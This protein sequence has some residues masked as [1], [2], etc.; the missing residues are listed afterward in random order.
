MSDLFLHGR[1]VDTVFDL[2][3]GQE[4]DITCSV[5]WALSQSGSFLRGLLDS[6][7][8]ASASVESATIRLQEHDEDGGYTDIEIQGDGYHLIVEAKRGWNLPGHHQLARYAGRLVAGAPGNQIVVLAE[9]SEQFAY[10]QLQLE[11]ISV[12]VEYRS[13]RSL[14]QI[15]STSARAANHAEKRLL[16]E[17]M[18]YLEGLMTMQDQESNRV[19]VVSLAGKPEWSAISFI[20]IVEKG[21]HYFHP[22]SGGSWPKVPPNYL[23]FRYRGRLQSIRHVDSYQILRFADVAGSIPEIDPT[24]ILEPLAS[25]PHFLYNLGQPI[26]PPCVV[27]PGAIFRNSRVWAAFDLLLTCSTLSEAVEKTRARTNGGK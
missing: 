1:P 13:W 19:Y 23:G 24:K 26:I 7:G 15:A 17:L 16:R 10:Q 8:M 2:L 9:C 21:G 3:G 11:G 25:T 12:P 5:G 6:L 20:D 27:K 18:H 22:V 14:Y 4:N